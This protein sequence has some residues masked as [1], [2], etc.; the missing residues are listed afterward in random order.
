MLAEECCTLEDTPTQL[1]TSVTVSGV[2]I[3]FQGPQAIAFNPTNTCVAIADWNLGSVGNV[4]LAAVNP[5]GTVNNTAA[6]SIIPPAPYSTFSKPVGLTFSTDG[7]WL[8]IADAQLGANGSVLIYKYNGCGVQ[9]TYYTTIPTARGITN[10]QT[11]GVNVSPN[12][13]YL[14][15]VYNGGFSSPGALVL[16]AFTTTLTTVT[17]SQTDQITG[18]GSGSLESAAFSTDNKY[19]AIG[20]TLPTSEVQFFP[21]SNGMFTSKVPIYTY[22]TGEPTVTFESV[23][24]AP[25]LNSPTFGCFAYA[26]EQVTPTPS[27]IL[28]YDGSG[29][30][31]LLTNPQSTTTVFVSPEQENFSPD[32]QILGVPDE[33]ARTVYIF[34]RSFAVLIT[35]SA[36]VCP[37]QS[38]TLTSSIVPGGSSIP[39]YTYTWTDPNGAVIGGNTSAITIPSAMA[40]QYM[41]TVQDSRGCITSTFYIVP[42]IITVLPSA[43]ITTAGGTQVTLAAN[44]KGGT[45]PYTVVWS[46]PGVPVDDTVN[47][48][49]VNVPTAPGAYT[50]SV[51]VTD[52]NG[53]SATAFI[54]IQSMGPASP[55]ITA[56][57]SKYCL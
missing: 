50:Y 57:Q 30:T 14:A 26:L 54:T 36:N 40:G 23:S 48:I 16:Y 12:G 44:A 31:P 33:G 6:L 10:E 39:P 37:G 56:I 25:S 8:L 34:T 27:I 49:I 35:P 4:Y 42:V 11:F 28:N 2:V 46:G 17:F 13:K 47:P 19:V 45:P 20:I 38:L 43:T 52:S 32:G 51:T 22:P 9:P 15:V 5:N 29:P 1:F 18:I 24:F 7:N 55:I 3:P 53:C 21:I 41:L